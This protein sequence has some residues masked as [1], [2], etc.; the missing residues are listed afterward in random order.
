MS[1]NSRAWSI[2]RSSA[3]TLVELL[4]V[5]AIIGVLIG[6]L[7]PAVQMAREAARR[8]SCQNNLKQLVLGTINYSESYRRLPIGAKTALTRSQMGW[9]DGYGWGVAILPFMEQ[10]ALFYA[11]REPF[12]PH[13]NGPQGTPGVFEMTFQQTGKILPDGA[14][15]LSVFRCPSSPLGKTVDNPAIP[16]QHGY[17]TSDYKG[18]SGTDDDGVFVKAGDEFRRRPLWITTA[19]VRDGLSNS[20]AIGESAYYKRIEVWPVWVGVILDDESCLFKTEEKAPINAKLKPKTLANMSNAV[21]D[22]SAFSWHGPGANFA[23]LDGS[24]HFLSET[25]DPVVYGRLGSIAD[26]LFADWNSEP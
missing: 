7:L 20:I 16:R 26:G 9:N 19:S 23:S 1:R 2:Y 18:C 15:H 10:E 13:A 8:I 24:V 21:S 11:L 4:V 17:A 22:D 5:I 6:L 12:L 25:I 14:T 3:F